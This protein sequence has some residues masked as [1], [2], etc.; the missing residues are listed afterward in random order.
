M[1]RRALRPAHCLDFKDALDFS[2]ATRVNLCVRNRIGSYCV[3]IYYKIKLMRYKHRTS[4]RWTRMLRLQCLAV[5]P[6]TAYLALYS[7]CLSPFFIG[8]HFCTNEIIESLTYA[9]YQSTYTRICAHHHRPAISVDLLIA[10]TYPT[11]SS[12]M[13]NDS[14]QSTHDKM[15]PHQCQWI[16]QTRN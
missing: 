8:N 11:L 7:T 15:C 10:D 6:R 13:T 14:S 1:S 3:S 4:H 5:K 12:S 16:K 9:L 2:L